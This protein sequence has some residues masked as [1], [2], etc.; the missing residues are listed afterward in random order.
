MEKGAKH[1]TLPSP[2]CAGAGWLLLLDPCKGMVPAVSSCSSPTPL[3]PSVGCALLA[4][5][6]LSLLY[7]PF[8]WLVN[9]PILSANESMVSG[10]SL[11][12]SIWWGCHH[13]IWIDGDMF[14]YL[15]AIFCV[16]K[17]RTGSHPRASWGLEV[18]GGISVYSYGKRPCLF[19]LYLY[20]ILW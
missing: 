9:I 1:R 11:V 14:S 16:K 12:R 10:A 7:T 18:G 2:S 5:S 19:M 20:T 3:L 13:I 6:R 8:L 15:E 4:A 17:K